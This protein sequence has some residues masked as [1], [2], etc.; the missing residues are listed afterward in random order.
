MGG[1]AHSAVS[2][3]PAN[4]FVQNNYFSN[5]GKSTNAVQSGVLP[6][7][8]EDSQLYISWLTTRVEGKGVLSFWWKCSAHPLAEEP[9]Q[10]AT[11]GRAGDIFQFGLYDSVGGITNKVA[12]LT[13]DED[14][15]HVVFTNEAETAVSFA[16][17]F[18]YADY[19]CDNG[20]GTGWVD[21]V[22]WTPE[23]SAADATATHGVPYSWLREKFDGYDAADA[24][25]LE[26][27]AMST[28]PGNSPDGKKW[29]D[30]T[31][32]MVW[33]DYWAGTDP[34]DSDDIFHAI[35]AINNGVPSI[36]PCP[37]MSTGTPAR[38]YWVQCAPTV[39]A[40][41]WERV[42]WP[43]DLTDP[44]LVTNRFFKVELDWEGSRQK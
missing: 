1:Q 24:D 44:A 2:G 6:I 38:V 20:G 35:I 23:G 5:D 36:T 10:A 25:T 19:G 13:G 31:P 37:D 27:L 4:W 16:W 3:Y 11:D 43:P 17:A 33:E 40:R 12:E 32:V 8:T 21:R 34:N 9:G 41:Y 42:R 26:N 39:S 14:W 18:I 22:T 29:P 28:S 7:N 30:G 15:C